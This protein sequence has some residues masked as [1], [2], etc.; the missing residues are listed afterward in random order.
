MQRSQ[1]FRQGEQW[2]QRQPL[3]FGQLLP[4]PGIP[5]WCGAGSGGQLLLQRQNRVADQ[6]GLLCLLFRQALQQALPGDPVKLRQ[7]P[8]PQPLLPLVAAEQALA[9]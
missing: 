4:E 8:E 3:L 9:A 6:L 7:L 2:Q 5:P 1:F